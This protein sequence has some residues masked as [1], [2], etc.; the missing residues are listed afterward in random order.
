MS[1]AYDEA[2]MAEARLF[3]VLLRDLVDTVPEPPQR[4]GR[5]RVPLRDALWCAVRKVGSQLSC[6]RAAGHFHAAVER[7]HLERAPNF[8]ITSRLLNRQDVTPVL[9]D[10]VTQSALPLAGMEEVFAVDSS[11]FRTTQFGAYRSERYGTPR[12]NVW[13]KA[14][15][16][17]GTRTHVIARATVTDGN[18]N[19]SPPFKHLV[20][21]AHDA[22]FH[23][24]EV[25]ADKAY[26]SRLNLQTVHNLGGMPYIPFRS[27]AEPRR[28]RGVIWWKAYHYFQ[29]HRPEFDAHYRKR[30][31]VECTFSALKRKFGE[32]LRSKNRVAQE[33][34]LLCKLLA[35]NIS[36]LIHEMH[37]TGTEPAF[38]VPAYPRSR[39]AA[40]RAPRGSRAY[41]GSDVSSLGG[42][43]PT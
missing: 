21:E 31:N 35:Y 3:D 12:R 26:S 28:G 42:S 22:G 9:R 37:E 5:P 34:E 2:Q 13:L 18:A 8:I 36:V 4:V 30:A 1:R 10:L 39:C 40:R 27:H 24:R 23:L 17:T 16:L 14:H 20:Q 25:V 6:R 43:F 11:G 19:D 7:R 38:L 29:L 41:D 15:I 33:N 32:T